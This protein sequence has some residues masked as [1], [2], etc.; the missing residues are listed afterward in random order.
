M[1]PAACGIRVQT[2]RAG[3]RTRMVTGSSVA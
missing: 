3:L 2:P 1:K